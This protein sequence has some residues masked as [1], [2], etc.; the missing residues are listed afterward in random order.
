MQTKLFTAINQ[1]INFSEKHSIIHNRSKFIKLCMHSKYF[2]T[3][4]FNFVVP[5]R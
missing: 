2:K 5:I 3:K 1:R 4:Y